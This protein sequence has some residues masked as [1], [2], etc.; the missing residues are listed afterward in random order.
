[1][2]PKKDGCQIGAECKESDGGYCLDEG[3]IYPQDQV[4]MTDAFSDT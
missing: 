1:M 3:D 2:E 4:L